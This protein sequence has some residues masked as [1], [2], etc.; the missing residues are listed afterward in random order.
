[1]KRLARLTFAAVCALPLAAQ[2]T[3]DTYQGHVVAANQILV[4]LRSPTQ[5]AIAGL[6]QALNADSVRQVGGSSGPLLFHSKSQNATQLM[7]SLTGRTDLEFAE[8]DYVVKSIATPNDPSFSQLWGMTKISVP[9]AWDVS[10]GS[11]SV[12]AAVVDTGM[13]YGHPDLAANVWSAPAAFTVNLSTG[14]ITCAAGSHGYNAV[15]HTCDPLDDNGHGTHVSGTIGAAGNNGVG[16]AGVNWTTRIMALKFLDSSGSGS[17]SDAID[18]IEFAIQ[19]KSIFGTSAGVRVLSASWGGDGYSQALYNEIVRAGSSDILFV[20]AAGN[21]A[22]NNDAIGFY[23]ADFSISNLIAVAATD[24]SD[25]LASFSNYGKQT[26]HLAAP[27]VNILSTYQSSY[28]YLSGTSMATPHV[29]GAAALVAAACGIATD[30]VKSALLNNVDAVSS[31]ASVTVS[32]GRLNVNKAVRSC[33][34]VASPVTSTGIWNGAAVTPDTAWVSDSP[35]TLGVKFRSDV[36][37]TV[38]GLRF[39]KGAGNNGT[40]VGLLYSA[41]G[42]VLAQA[43]FTGESSSGWQTVTFSPTVSITAN[44]TYVAAYWSTSG[45]AVSRY[46]FTS[47]G[48]TNGPLH[49]LQS[50]VDGTNGVYQYGSAPQFPASTWQDSNYWVDIV[51]TPTGTAPVIVSLWSG[52]AVSPESPWVAD[53]SPVT[54][55]TKFRSD[56]AASVTGLRFW[57]GN[58]SENGTHTALLYNSSGQL[59]AQATFA[60]ETGSGWQ[61]ATFTS[62]VAIVANTTYVAAY[63]TAT[64]YP[65]SR[66]FFTSQGVTNGSLHA[67]QAGVDGPNGLYWYGSAPQLPTN[68]WQ[69]TNY[70][71]DVLVA[72]GQ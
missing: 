4:K 15:A 23:P 21:S 12:V 60:N 6:T 22:A 34:T 14:S 37:G 27:G 70:W 39:Y 42:A 20:A 35:V 11:A 50:G 69:D 52:A 58:A 43:T 5:S 62:P 51:F 44:T 2:P 19:A 46:F 61:T 29:S 10:T 7:M 47:Q 32:G 55:G 53:Y 66:Y 41:A 38:T 18:A 56:V 49:A 64:G 36:S 72:I 33:A 40:H 71:I 63:W 48:I 65:A 24:S 9:S 16:V 25:A 30:A 54:L 45:F 1:L 31:L 59:L 26:V 8:P 28:A 68:T 13:N 57:K 67:L 17:V 3:T